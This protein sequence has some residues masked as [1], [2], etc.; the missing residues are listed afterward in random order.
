MKIKCKYCN[1]I[2]CRRVLSGKQLFSVGQEKINTQEIRAKGKIHTLPKFKKS[3]KTQTYCDPGYK[4]NLKI[5]YRMPI[6]CHT[7]Q[8]VS[9]EETTFTKR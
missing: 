8:T 7:K 1:L 6:K 2:P 5:N 4:R 3:T 9:P